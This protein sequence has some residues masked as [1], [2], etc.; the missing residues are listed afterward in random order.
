MRNWK[1]VGEGMKKESSL[2][3]ENQPRGESQAGEMRVGREEA[4]LSTMKSLKMAATL[5]TFC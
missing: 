1:G 3:S 2:N 5:A 4:G